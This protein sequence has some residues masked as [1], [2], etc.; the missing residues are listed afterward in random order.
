MTL[1][2]S[3]PSQ[4]EE[5]VAFIAEE[6]DI[7]ELQGDS[8]TITLREHKKNRRRKGEVDVYALTPKATYR[9]A[10]LNTDELGV[11]NFF[12]CQNIFNSW[13]ILYTICILSKYEA[14]FTPEVQ[15]SS[16]I[17]NVSND[18]KISCPSGAFCPKN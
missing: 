14:A 13:V 16:V 10:Q 2:K 4:A 11:C 17:D 1:K 8:V 3:L 15:R 12:S 7:T 18:I 5:D 9:F 6:W